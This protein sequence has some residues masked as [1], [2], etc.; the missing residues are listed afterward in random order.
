MTYIN[1]K[2]KDY[3]IVREISTSG[4]QGAVYYATN[5]L[6]AGAAIKI[7]HK[8]LT[9]NESFRKHFKKEAVITASIGHDHIVRALD[10]YEDGETVAIIMEYLEGQDLQSY[11]EQQGESRVVPIPLAMKWYA[12]IL[13]AFAHA[14]QKGLVHRDVKPSNFFLTTSGNVKILDFGI[15]KI[16]ESAELNGDVAGSPSVM[17]QAG[18]A[19]YKSKE[20]VLRPASVNHLTDVYALGLMFYIITTGKEPFD[21]EQITDDI[22]NKELPPVDGYPPRLMQVLLRATAKDRDNRYRD[23]LSFLHALET[24][25]ANPDEN[26]EEYDD[27]KENI[28]PPQ[29]STR[30]QNTTTPPPPVPPPPVGPRYGV[31]SSAAVAFAAFV[32]GGFGAGYFLSQNSKRL[33]GGRNSVAYLMGCIVVV[34]TA[35]MFLVRDFD[36]TDVWMVFVLIQVMTAIIAFVL[37]ESGQKKRIEE[38]LRMGGTFEPLSGMIGLLITFAIINMTVIFF[39]VA[40]IYYT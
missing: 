8:N 10:F 23:C 25:V 33:E 39:G 35:Y 40:M 14:H 34:F 13:P 16:L 24:A 19:Y 32:G 38:H 27:L 3:T 36:E 2:I 37:V 22:L 28:K 4:G 26:V 12:Q 18:T 9:T 15:A 29:E 31:Y 1:T 5:S 11:M 20:H 21:S 30:Q 6:G 7:L 17:S